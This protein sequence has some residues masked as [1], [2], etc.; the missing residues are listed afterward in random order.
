MQIIVVSFS[1]SLQTSGFYHRLIDLTHNELTHYLKPY[2]GPGKAP[3]FYK[4]C[5]TVR[6]TSFNHGPSIT[7][8]IAP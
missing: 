2:Y 4:L 5:V 3:T 7:A 8:V 6:A 1:D